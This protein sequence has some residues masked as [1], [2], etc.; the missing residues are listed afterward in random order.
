MSQARRQSKRRSEVSRR[1]RTEQTHPE[2]ALRALLSEL[3]IQTR[4]NVRSL[5]GTPDLVATDLNFAAFVHG[6][7]WHGHP[8]CPGKRLPATNAWIWRDRLRATQLRDRRVVQELRKLGMVVAV[9]WECEFKDL[10]RLKKRLAAIR[11]RLLRD[12]V[13]DS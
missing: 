6:C 10:P 1:R 3:G 13:D 5:P 11:R 12:T 8:G 4:T 9:V 2:L 7:F